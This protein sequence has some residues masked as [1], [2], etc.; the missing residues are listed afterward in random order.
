M[1]TNIDR[2]IICVP[3]YNKHGKRVIENC[4]FIFINYISLKEYVIYIWIIIA[5]ISIIIIIS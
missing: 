2:C 5:G 3:N 1:G 4:V